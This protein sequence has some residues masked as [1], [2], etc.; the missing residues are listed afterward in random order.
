M[1][2]TTEITTQRE[3]RTAFGFSMAR[4]GAGARSRPARSTTRSEASPTSSRQ[5]YFSTDSIYVKKIEAAG[6]EYAIL[7]SLRV[8]HSGDSPED[9]PPSDKAR[10]HERE[11]AIQR[12]KDHVKRAL[13]RLPGVRAAEI[14]VETGSMTRM[15]HRCVAAHE[16]SL[17]KASRGGR[18]SKTRE[19]AEPSRGSPYRRSAIADYIAFRDASTFRPW[20]DSSRV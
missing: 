18:M 14:S 3:P 1:T 9:P 13:L 7:S 6:Y 2:A 20:R 19:R 4:Q 11:A 12:R 15:R 10:F 5:V 16:L 17:T 8:R